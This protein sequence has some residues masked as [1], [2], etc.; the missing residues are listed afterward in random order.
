[1]GADVPIGPEIDLIRKPG[2][3][4][5]CEPLGRSLFIFSCHSVTTSAV[6]ELCT[7]EVQ[8][9]PHIESVDFSRLRLRVL[10]N[11]HR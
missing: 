7:V 8:A 11:V 9:F 3:W 4:E 1:M 5:L 2:A 6:F 10:C